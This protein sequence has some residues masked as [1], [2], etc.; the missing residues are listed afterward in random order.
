VGGA[1]DRARGTVVLK[2]EYADPEC[3][4]LS[5]W[6][7]MRKEPG[8]PPAAGD[9]HWQRVMADRTVTEDGHVARCIDCHRTYD[10]GA[11]LSRDWMCTEP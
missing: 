8:Y 10:L 9:W 11:C 4:E 1:G 3:R 2:E 5:A 7:V 6:T